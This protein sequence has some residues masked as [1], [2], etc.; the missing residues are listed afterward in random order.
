[1]KKPWQSH[2]A[3]AVSVESG[4][5]VLDLVRCDKATGRV[6]KSC[7]VPLGAD[8][9]CED[10][11]RAGREAASALASV[12]ISERR[13]VVCVPP[14][15][16]LTTSADVPQVGADD[17]RSY[18]E[19]RA[20][21]ELPVAAADSRIAHCA[22][23][24]P[25]GKQR[26]TLAAI[27]AKR[28]DAVETMLA[29]SGRRAVSESLGLDHCASSETPGGLHFLS[30]GNHVDV[31]VATGGGIAAV[32]SLPG[33]ATPG[34]S[35]FDAASFVREVRI[36]L[37]GLPAPVR[38]QLRE[39]RFSGSPVASEDLCAGIRD[40]L[41]RMGIDS[42]L[43]RPG[44][45]A[46]DH[47]SAAVGAAENF[48]RSQPVAFEFVV[49]Q[50]NRWESALRQFDSGQRRWMAVAAVAFIVLPALAFFVRSRIE[51]RLE[52]RW[53]GMR[54][55]VSEVDALQQK[56]R[57]FRPWFDKTPQSVRLLDA[58]TSAFPES[59]E[60]WAKSIHV[61]DEFKVTC[62]GFARSQTDLTAMLDRLR[63]RTDITELRVQQERGQNPIQFSFT[64]KWGVRDAK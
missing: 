59:G 48:L 41:G 5:I 22:Y 42:K 64:Y 52:S 54:A 31:V 32:R 57:Q 12:G 13:C 51:S 8:A 18:L 3:L 56:I 62:A 14:G 6:L 39:A 60:V 61:A 11:D 34:G 25:D 2:T 1:M 44:G 55:N 27:P 45:G 43:Q 50:T 4:R 58:L 23:A 10:P 28:L 47:P 63:A 16:A 38:E 40:A 19:L 46:H 36:T 37:G 53:D 9:V 24:L 15:W 35:S 17:L 7:V 21:K 20:E 33:P 30:N 26:A 49:P 29:V